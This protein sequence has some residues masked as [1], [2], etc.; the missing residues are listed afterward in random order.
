MSSKLKFA[1]FACSQIQVL[2]MSARVNDG[3]TLG[4]VFAKDMQ[5]KSKQVDGEKDV[6]PLSRWKM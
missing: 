6:H 5:R 4:A 2:R 3:S 1:L